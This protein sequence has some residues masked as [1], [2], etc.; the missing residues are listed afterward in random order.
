MKVLDEERQKGV[1]IPMPG[2][3]DWQDQ[4]IVGSSPERN[5]MTCL[6]VESHSAQSRLEEVMGRGRQGDGLGNVLKGSEMLGAQLYSVTASFK[7]SPAVL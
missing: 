6:S 2:V 3:W 4:A 1:L 5:T 7:P